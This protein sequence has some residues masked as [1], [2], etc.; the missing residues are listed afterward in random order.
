[1]PGLP[2]S[3]QEHDLIR[4]FAPNYAL[5]EKM[6][7]DRSRKQ[8]CDHAVRIGVAKKRR[9]KVSEFEIEI[10]KRFWPDLNAIV[11]EAPELNKTLVTRVACKRLGLKNPRTHVDFS[12][13]ELRAWKDGA[14]RLP[15]RSMASVHS[16]RSKLKFLIQPRWTSAEKSS[17]K[18]DPRA[19]IAGRT[20]RATRVIRGQLGI[21]LRKIRRPIQPAAPAGALIMNAVQRAIPRTLPRQIQQEVLSDLAL[22]ILEGEIEL[23]NVATAVSKAIKGVYKRYPVLGAPVSLDMPLFDDGGAT[24]GDRITSDTFHF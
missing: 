9:G 12:T 14:V 3:E 1:M 6:L 5:L 21:D 18:I 4:R 23:A 16:K 11:S 24:L 17:L 2:W 13:Q 8:I 7:P 15:G 20:E 10:I 19:A 22:A